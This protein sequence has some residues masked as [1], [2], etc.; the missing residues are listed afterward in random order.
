MPSK[1][2][3]RIGVLALQGSFAEHAAMIR[4]LGHEAYEIRSLEDV[5]RIDP[6][7]LILPG[8]ESTTMMKFLEKNAL[9]DWLSA[10]IRAGTPVLATCAGVILLSRS[11]LNLLDIDV[12]R[13]AYGSQ[14]DS[15]ETAINLN[16]PL[17]TGHSSPKKFPAI[18]IRAPRI[19]K[20]GLKVTTLAAIEGE[21]ILVQQDKILGATF[22]P[23]LTK[24]TRIH[25]ILLGFLST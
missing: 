9:R 1:S 13:N 11:H 21:P 2:K 15:F 10:A 3:K 18:F 24:D 12:D 5:R 23:E 4:K 20:T 14:L 22:H 25:K 6:Q 16:A 17:V 7:A 19:K 8:G